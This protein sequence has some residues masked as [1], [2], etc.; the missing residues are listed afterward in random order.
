[1]FNYVL[2]RCSGD[3]SVSRSAKLVGDTGIGKAIVLP[4]QCASGDVIVC[5]CKQ[6][7]VVIRVNAEKIS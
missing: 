2:Q 4:E 3:Q 5:S 7:I 1:M 6:G